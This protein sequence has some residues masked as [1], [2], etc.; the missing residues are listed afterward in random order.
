MAAEGNVRAYPTSGRLQPF[1]LIGLGSML[2][3][4]TR[5]TDQSFFDAG[6]AARFG[7]GFDL[8]TSETISFTFASSY[9]LATGA[10]NKWNTVDLTL[11][12]QYRF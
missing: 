3:D 12:L 1:I 9:V 8:Y 5:P 4:G 2:V 7:G 10:A 6:F 11:G